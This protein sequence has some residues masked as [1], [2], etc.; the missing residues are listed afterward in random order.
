[1]QPMKKLPKK[2]GPEWYIQQSIIK[3]LKGLDWMV[4]PTHGNMFQSGF[5]DLYCFHS[6]YGQRWV[7]VK[8]KDSYKFTPAQLEWFPRFSAVQCGIWILVSDSE[9][10]YKKLFKP[11]N[12][13][14]YL[15]IWRGAL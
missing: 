3:K 9:E 1:M 2:K 12:W 10:E 5:P 8:N 14:I 6:H 15:S 13:H 4:K 11:A 7:E